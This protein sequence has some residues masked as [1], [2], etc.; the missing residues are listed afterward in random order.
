MPFNPVSL[1]NL[2]PYPPGT[3]GTAGVK[4]VERMV[5]SAQKA[6]PQAMKLLRQAMRN[7]ELPMS[8][9]LRCAEYIVDKA[10]PKNAPELA[11]SGTGLEFLEL[12]FVAPG[13]QAKDIP[14]L[15]AQAIS[16]TY[17]QDSEISHTSPHT[18]VEQESEE[19]Q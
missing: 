11:I 16:S 10:W 12:R 14:S 19:D 2:K 7:P 6:S 5:A 13:Q 8:T 1:A 18:D 3:Q 17:E 15:E 9:R 4:Y